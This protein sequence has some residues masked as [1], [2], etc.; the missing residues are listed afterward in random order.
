MEA[1]VTLAEER[2]DVPEWAV[3]EWAWLDAPELGVVNAGV[4]VTGTVAIGMAIG[5][6]TGTGTIM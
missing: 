3:Q 6:I 2:P 1:E 4:V 5:T